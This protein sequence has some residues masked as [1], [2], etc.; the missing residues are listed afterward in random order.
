MEAIESIADA[1]SGVAA[2]LSLWDPKAQY[3][4]LA[5]ELPLLSRLNERWRFK[6]INW[7]GRQTSLN[8]AA[9]SWLRKSPS[10]NLVPSTSPLWGGG[11]Y[12]CSLLWW[13]ES[14]KK[15]TQGTQLRIYHKKT[16]QFFCRKQSSTP[17]WCNFNCLVMMKTFCVFVKVK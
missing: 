8:V 3:S 17:S 6:S 13:L 14:K 11:S 12:K 9:L 1:V 5:A 10:C 2:I 7:D 4:L 15:D 16:T